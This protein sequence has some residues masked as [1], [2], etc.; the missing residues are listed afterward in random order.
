MCIVTYLHSCTYT[1]SRRFLSAK[2]P[3]IGGKFAGRDLQDV[4]VHTNFCIEAHMVKCTC[5]IKIVIY[6][7]MYILDDTCICTHT[8][9]HTHT[10][11]HTLGAITYVFALESFFVSF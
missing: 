3:V 10:H 6:I 1:Y 8:H 9:T 2:E 5:N 4:C 11:K 7:Y